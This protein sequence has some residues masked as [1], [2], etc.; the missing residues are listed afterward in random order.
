MNHQ[1]IDN[2]PSDDIDLLQLIKSIL[3]TWKIVFI[4]TI[5]TTAAYAGV[6]AL[7]ALI[8]SDER[9]FQKPIKLTF[10]GAHDLKFASGARFRYSDIVAPAVVQKVYERNNIATTGLSTTQF[11]S[12]LTAFPYSPEY[13]AIYEKFS[14]LMGDKKLSIEQIDQLRVQMKAELDQASSGAAVISWRVNNSRVSQ[15]LANR[16]LSDIPAVWAEINIKSKG[17]LQLNTSI[18]TTNSLNL[19]LINSTDILIT[20]DILEEKLQVLKDNI[21]ALS[22]FGAAKT[23][24]DPQTGMNLIDLENA[25]SD[26]RR[27]DIAKIL[28]PFQ[29]RGLSNQPEV[30][31]FYFEDKLFK[32]EREYN[33]QK[34]I[35]DGI[36]Q[37]LLNYSGATVQQVDI[38]ASASFAPQISGDL[39]DKLSQL[40]GT[41]E[42]ELFIQNLTER[43]LKVSGQL[44]V[45]QTAIDQTKLVLERLTKGEENKASN[46]V[47]FDH[48]VKLLPTIVEKITAYYGVFDRISLLLESELNG[49]IESLYV[50]ITNGILIEKNILNI[51]DTLI[52]WILLMILTVVVVIP[53]TLIAR[54]IKTKNA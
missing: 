37:V 41:A 16:V 19:D 32:L 1:V 7:N 6:T 46:Q 8:A 10:P 30:T 42:K 25:I 9:V 11:Q 4:A 14:R 23:L 12:S 52:Y 39:I 27:Y 17:V 5:I 36:K 40:A 35:A 50:P 15:E 3:S 38:G 43:W 54:A 29:L 31:K 20:G 44:A 34:N 22:E 48:G 47:L 2:A 21:R 18:S 24:A 13:P 26:L 53:V 45:L 33:S 49:S 28:A 51:K